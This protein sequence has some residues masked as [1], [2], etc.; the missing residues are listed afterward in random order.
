M[1]RMRRE[2]NY[3]NGVVCLFFNFI[4]VE[5]NHNSENRQSMFVIK[6]THE[7]RKEYHT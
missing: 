1:K 6:K 2:A 4:I 5:D 3:K 7:M